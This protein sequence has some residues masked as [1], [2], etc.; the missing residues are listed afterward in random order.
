MRSF[1]F[2]INQYPKWACT[3]KLFKKIFFPWLPRLPKNPRKDQPVNKSEVRR[4]GPSL[5]LRRRS[6]LKRR[7]LMS[8]SNGNSDFLGRLK[9]QLD[10]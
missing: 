9:K 1:D 7:S 5:K 10:T 6:S 3:N 8:H 4:H 2:H